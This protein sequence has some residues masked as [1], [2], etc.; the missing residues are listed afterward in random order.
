MILIPWYLVFWWVPTGHVSDAW[1]VA[2]TFIPISFGWAAGDVSLAAYVQ[3]LLG[4][5]EKE[6]NDVSPLGAVMSFLYCT[7]IVTYAIASTFLGQYVDAVGN[8]PENRN[9]GT[10]PNYPS[11]PNDYVNV[12]PA[13]YNVV[14]VQFTVLAVIMLLATF[15]PRGAL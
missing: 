8:R 12:R 7:Y 15:I 2:A 3:A 6:V 10:P 9:T 13:I 11:F 14:G 5:E 4:C 1:K